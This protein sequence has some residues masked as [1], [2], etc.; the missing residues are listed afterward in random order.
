MIICLEGIDA[1]GKATQA[2]RFVA[3]T[4][5][6]L[7]SFPDYETPSGQLIRANLEDDADCAFSPNPLHRALVLQSLMLTNRMEKAPAIHTCRMNNRDVV[8]DRYWPS[9]LVYGA[10]D[11]L[12]Y[13]WLV[14]IHK[15]LPQA[16][17]Y[18]LLDIDPELSAERRPDRRDRYE[19]QPGLMEDAAER[20]RGVWLSMQQYHMSSWHIIDASA[21]PDD[22]EEA[23]WKRMHPRT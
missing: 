7:F 3:R 13:D 10:A 9:G 2:E 16:H 4:R 15:H 1:C 11:G 5:A 6:E 17:H 14:E 12:D 21:S 22:V 23:I 20:Y 8:L 19:K 18:F